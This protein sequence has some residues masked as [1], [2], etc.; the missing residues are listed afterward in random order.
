MSHIQEVVKQSLNSSCD[1][2]PSAL[3][4]ITMEGWETLCPVPPLGADSFISAIFTM[5][6]NGYGINDHSVI[7]ISHLE[8]K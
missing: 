8:S 1:P 6:I 4:F 2:K 3:S 5:Y 7:Y